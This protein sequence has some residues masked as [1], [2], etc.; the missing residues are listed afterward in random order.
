MN[1]TKYLSI[2]G[3]ALSKYFEEENITKNIVCIAMSKYLSEETS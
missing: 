2:I 3:S 1:K